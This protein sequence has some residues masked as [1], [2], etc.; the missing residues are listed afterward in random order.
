VTTGSM[1]LTA[2]LAQLR[3]CATRPLEQAFAMP[4]GVYTSQAFLALEL[5]NIF[6]LE[7]HCIGRDR[8]L[9]TTGDYLTLEIADEPILVIRDDAGAVRAF[10]NVC[11]HRM[12]R[13]LDGSGCATRITCPY[14]AW[15]YDLDG[16]LVAAPF[17]GKD[18]EMTTYRL[19]EL[20][21]EVWEGWIYVA[22]ND[23]APPLGQRLEGLRKA[24]AN[25]R[26]SDYEPL[27]RVDECWDTNWKC[28][29]EN[30]IDAYHLFKVHATTVEPALP[31]R[32]VRCVPGG[33]AYSLSFQFRVADAA[34]EYDKEL[35][36]FN[37]SLTEEERR[38]YPLACVYPAHL[39]AVSPDRLFWLSVRPHGT[40][41]TKVRWGVDVFPG[42]VPKGTEGEQRAQQLRGA[43]DRINTEDKHILTPL[44]R[45]A[46][47]VYAVPGPLTPQ[48]RSIWE[49]S[50]YVSRRLC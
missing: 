40:G 27:F 28:L 36:A 49:F 24:L 6:Q 39:I 7:W 32:L 22:L 31:T 13:L 44:R 29:V 42:V 3:D 46:E 10:S 19:P 48:E 14:H 11:R 30:F 41:R 18:F 43:F 47:S 34:F 45:N 4:P 38:K 25:Y 17:M 20:P 35:P 23:R 50:R 37:E 1:T 21:V 33:D 15:T 9:P 16:R 12:S 2:L 5:E 26:M 8:E